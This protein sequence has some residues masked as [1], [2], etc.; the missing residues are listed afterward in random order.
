MNRHGVWCLW[1]AVLLAAAA[2]AAGVWCGMDVAGVWWLIAG[3]AV[4]AAWVLYGAVAWE[5][6][7]TRR[8][9]EEHCD[10]EPLLTSSRELRA[11]LH[12]RRRR[13][14][15]GWL[16]HGLN[17]F[18]AL[19]EL[20][21]LDEAETLLAQLEPWIS[22]SALPIQQTSFAM[23]KAALYLARRQPDEA[24]PWIHR[25]EQ[26]IQQVALSRRA[27]DTFRIALENHRWTYR[28]LTEESSQELL[29]M[30]LQR[31]AD[32]GT[33]RV[34]VRE[35]YSV[36]LCLLSL[37]RPEEARPHLEFVVEHG[38]KLA[39]RQEARQRLAELESPRT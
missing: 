38:G 14:R 37:G 2:G 9:L 21:R 36:S 6:R 29:H 13:E 18:A 39:I 10:P 25:S 20:G 27:Q 28:F 34:R 23:D 5:S 17:E 12:P 26:S 7:M 24:L 31:A 8:Q 32:A 15:G 19:Y 11:Q 35:Q 3:T 30:A 1:I 4:A 33:L 22:P 16:G